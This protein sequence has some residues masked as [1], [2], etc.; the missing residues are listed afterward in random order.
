MLLHDSLLD[1]KVYK[2]TMKLKLEIDYGF[3]I[4]KDPNVGTLAA[5][6][7]EPGGEA[8]LTMTSRARTRAAPV[9][10]SRRTRGGCNSSVQRRTRRMI[11]PEIAIR[12]W[13]RYHLEGSNFYIGDVGS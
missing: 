12:A 6:D 10:D 9:S 8:F 3:S 2:H 5:L 4:M 1:H 13:E 11:V 7:D